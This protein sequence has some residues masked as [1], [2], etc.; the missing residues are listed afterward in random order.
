[1]SKRKISFGVALGGLSLAVEGLAGFALLPI[2]LHFLSDELAGVWVLYNSFAGLIGLSQNGFGPVVMRMAAEI[3]GTARDDFSRFYSVVTWSFRV[4]L[5]IIVI[6]TA[7][8][9]FVYLRKVLAPLG[10]VDTGTQVWILVACGHLVR[11]YAMRNIHIINGY[12]E[13]G[14]DKVLQLGSTVI[15]TTG[16]II[17]LY[18]GAGL[19]GLGII[20]LSAC[21]GYWAGSTLLLRHFVHES[22]IPYKGPVK[23]LQIIQ[24]F[25]DSGKIFILNLSAFFSMSFQVYIIERL[26]GVGIL[27]FYN[28]L[29]RVLS[30]IISVSTIIQQMTY[31]YVALHWFQK[32][33]E[34]CRRLY[35]NGVWIS[36]GAAFIMSVTAF[37]LAPVIIPLWLGEGAYL[38]G[39]VF[40]LMLLYGLVYIHHNAHATPAIA[41]GTLTFI[42]PAVVIAVFCVPS[43]ILGGIYFGIPGVVTGNILSTVFPSIYVVWLSY[44]LFYNNRFKGGFKWLAGLKLP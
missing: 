42:A 40:G 43:S 34:K 7:A 26:F 6:I 14:W 18:S 11:A 13:L 27:P 28:A 4:V 8:V 33:Y 16:Y 32:N 19:L 20:L 44:S 2:L 3:K 1:M 23:M 37:L 5:I 39:T 9:Y 24:L 38:G 29:A 25:K 36:V 21:S 22:R 10:C 17:V 30:L 31:P 35:I 15:T 12:G 41:T